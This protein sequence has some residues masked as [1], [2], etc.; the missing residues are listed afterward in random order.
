MER[1]LAAIERKNP[2]A[3]RQAAID[4]VKAARAAAREV[5]GSRE[6]A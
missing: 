4:H 6:A 2:A 1:M 3:A 5:F